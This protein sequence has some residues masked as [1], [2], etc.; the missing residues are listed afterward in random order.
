ML[1]KKRLGSLLDFGLLCWF[2][3]QVGSAF[4]LE[5][6]NDSGWNPKLYQ[7]Y[8]AQSGAYTAHIPKAWKLTWSNAPN[9]SE[10]SELQLTAPGKPWPEHVTISVLHYAGAHRT[11]ERYLFDIQHPTI[12]GKEDVYGAIAEV[13]VAGATAKTLDVSTNRYPP[14]GMAGD[15]VSSF[16]HYVVVP[17]RQGFFVLRYDAPEHLAITYRGIFDFLV[18]SFAPADRKPPSSQDQIPAK[19]YDVYEALFN[20]QPP[21]ASNIPEFFDSVLKCRLVG[22][23]T[24]SSQKPLSLAWLKKKFNALDPDLVKDY[25]AKNQKAW[26]LKDRIMVS[27]LQVLPSEELNNHL[28]ASPIYLNGGIVTLSRVGFNSAGN[29]ALFSVTIVFPSELRA[30]YIVFMQKNNRK[31]GLA[32]VEM[33][34]I[35]YN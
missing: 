9:S 8:K 18:E 26:Q 25:L 21:K 30:S 29:S 15:K 28:S 24:L 31:W 7:I 6:S 4:A 14:I 2:L 33:E 17:S 12:G 35:I 27:N 20:S 22:E 5:N 11:S 34:S 23:R 13:M 19:E 16:I 1:C 32:K 3:A 10:P